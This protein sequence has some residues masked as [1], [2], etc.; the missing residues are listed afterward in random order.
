M[1]IY[2]YETVSGKSGEKPTQYEIKQGMHDEPLTSHPETGE[3]IRRIIMGGLGVLR[4]TGKEKQAEKPGSC[5]GGS[6]CCGG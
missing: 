3:V 5:C 2:L 4:S 1:P 6:G